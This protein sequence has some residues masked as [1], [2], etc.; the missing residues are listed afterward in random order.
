MRVNYFFS[1]HRWGLPLSKKRFVS[2]CI[3]TLEE[4]LKISCQKERSRILSQVW[5]LFSS[6]QTKEPKS[7]KIKELHCD[8]T[9]FE[10]ALKSNATREA[11]ECLKHIRQCL[12]EL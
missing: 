4:S 7:R 10:N 9:C 3:A 8:L 11:E 2:Q 6:L 1:S 5:T 12:E